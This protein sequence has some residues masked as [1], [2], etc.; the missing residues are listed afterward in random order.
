MVLPFRVHGGGLSCEVLLILILLLGKKYSTGTGMV[1]KLHVYS[2]L[3]YSSYT[4]TLSSSVLFIHSWF[5]HLSLQ[6]TCNLYDIIIINHAVLLLQPGPIPLATVHV[7]I[8]NRI[9]NCYYNE[10]A[11]IIRNSTINIV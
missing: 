3:I 5:Y 11:Y 2:D 6:E 1:I 10:T 7:N 9:N 8:I 4:L